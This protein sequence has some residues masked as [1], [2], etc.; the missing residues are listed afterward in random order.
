MNG[1]SIPWP[2]K[3]SAEQLISLFSLRRR[4]RQI[5][6]WSGF[7]WRDPAPLAVQPRGWLIPIE[8]E[9]IKHSAKNVAC[10]R[11]GRPAEWEANGVEIRSREERVMPGASSRS[12]L[13]K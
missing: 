3:T 5:L 7:G 12:P 10:R 13:H 6:P 1:L 2:V 8:H 9:L 11:V 4:V